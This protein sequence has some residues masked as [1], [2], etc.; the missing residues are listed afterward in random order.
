MRTNPF[1]YL[2]SAALF[3]LCSQI[4]HAGQRLDLVLGLSDAQ[5]GGVDRLSH[6][7]DLPPGVTRGDRLAVRVPQQGAYPWSSNLTIDLTEDIRKGDVC[8]L[9]VW[10]R[11]LDSM[12]GE[13]SIVLNVEKE[14]GNYDKQAAFGYGVPAQW[15]RFDVPFEAWFDLGAGQGRIA[16]H[17]G[18]TRQELELAGLSLVR[19]P[20]GTD[21]ASLPRSEV[22]YKGRDADAEWRREALE[23]IERVRTG[24]IRVRVVDATGNSV[25]GAKIEAT[26]LRSAFSFGT[27]IAARMFNDD[28][29]SAPKYRDIASNLFSEVVFEN[30]MK[31]EHHGLGDPD[32]IEAALRWAERHDITVRGHTLIWPSWNNTP[33]HVQTF[34]TDPAGLRAL[35]TERVASTAQ[36]YRG[37]L[38]DWDVVNEPYTNHDITDILGRE[39]L[40]DWYRVARRADP[41]AKLYLNDYGILAAGPSTT[42]HQD[43]FADTIGFLIEQGAPIDGVGI[44]GHFGATL[45][46]PMRM[47]EILDRYAAFGLPIKITEYDL[48]SDDDALQA[49]FMRDVLI[50][51]YSHP[52]VDGFL[53][54]GFWAG[55]HWRPR[56]AMYDEDWTPRPHAAVWKEWVLDRWA[57]VAPAVS[58]ANGEAVLRAHHGEYTISVTSGGGTAARTVTLDKAGAEVVVTVER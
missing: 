45:T 54:W 13:G 10:A 21:I 43:H 3:V 20:A 53:V 57:S 52:A 12:T 18:S 8:L 28:D 29:P 38:V 37:R 16:I 35:V 49:D 48:D 40:A 34:A 36:Q 41:N 4:T 24:P 6:A 7:G 26:Q 23:R 25:A 39:S 19:M 2:L 47:Q 22:T 51:C 17:I 46:T 32:L 55:Q 27:A 44:Q 30:A 1:L 42:P 14:G 56:A 15:K 5:L 50:A 33:S 58:D 9:T 11:C 31:W